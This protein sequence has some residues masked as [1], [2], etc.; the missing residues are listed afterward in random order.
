MEEIPNL[1]ATLPD[2]SSTLDSGRNASKYRGQVFKAEYKNTYK[3]NSNRTFFGR[4]LDLQPVFEDK[5]LQGV[6]VMYKRG[7]FVNDRW[8]EE[9][10]VRDDN[11]GPF[12]ALN[13]FAAEVKLKGPDDDEPISRVFPQWALSHDSPGNENM[14]LTITMLPA[15]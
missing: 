1:F 10:E 13:R 15:L 11:F 5:T 2:E 4:V 8:T 9:Q 12:T 14:R 3:I 7:K 6:R